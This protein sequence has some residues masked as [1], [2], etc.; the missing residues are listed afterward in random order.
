[1]M[2]RACDRQ[3]HISRRAAVACRA[4]LAMPGCNPFAFFV[5]AAVAAAFLRCSHAEAVNH[6]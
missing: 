2:V 3:S 5:L 4:L 6:H 1:M